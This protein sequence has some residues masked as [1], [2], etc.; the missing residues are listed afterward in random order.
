MYTYTI[1]LHV[2]SYSIYL[3]VD[4]VAGPIWSITTSG[5][6]HLHLQFKGMHV[7][8]CCHTP[9]SRSDEGARAMFDLPLATST[10]SA[11]LLAVSAASWVHRPRP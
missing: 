6:R 5:C 4:D 2:L 1:S 9:G 3:F 8:G 7:P 10:S 11:P